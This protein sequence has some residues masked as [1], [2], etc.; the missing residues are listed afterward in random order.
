L[1]EDSGLNAVENRA[2]IKA[3]V[4][5]A[6][7]VRDV[8]RRRVVGELEHGTSVVRANGDFGRLEHS[9]AV[10]RGERAKRP[11]TNIHRPRSP[12]TKRRRA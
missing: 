4:D 3:H 10:Q 2:R 9:C 5:V 6:Q 7:E 8:Q 11:Q 12:E 1:N